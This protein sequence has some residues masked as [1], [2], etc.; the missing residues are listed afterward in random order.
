[1]ADIHVLPQRSDAADLVMPSKLTGML[2]SGK[3]VITTASPNTELAIELSAII[4]IVPTDNASAL[5]EALRYFARD[6]VAREHQ[7]SLGYSFVL[8]HWTRDK[9]LG[10]IL[11]KF[12]H[13]VQPP[14]AG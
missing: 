6:K 4:R 3:P 2:A 9:V 11:V 8:Q 14:K 5:A 10:D 13:L 7:G 1:M 12:E